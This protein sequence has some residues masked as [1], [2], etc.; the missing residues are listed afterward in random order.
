MLVTDPYG[1]DAPFLPG[2]T[3]MLFTHPSRPGTP[4][5]LRNTQWPA[6]IRVC[7][8]MNHPVPIHIEL[9]AA[10]MSSDAWRATDRRWYR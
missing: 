3:W 2:I 10:V 7:G 9:S 5:F 4:L 6:V 1:S 8:P